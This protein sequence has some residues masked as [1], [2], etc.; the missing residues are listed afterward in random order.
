MLILEQPDH[1]FST[2][3]GLTVQ[4]MYYDW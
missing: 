3:F 2:H 4:Y 1:F